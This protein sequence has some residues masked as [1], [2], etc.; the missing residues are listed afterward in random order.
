MEHETHDDSNEREKELAMVKATQ[1][2][3]EEIFD[4]IRSYKE[5]HRPRD[6]LNVLTVGCGGCTS[7]CMAGGQREV[8]ALN[9]ELTEMARGRKVP[10]RFSCTTVERQCNP[11]FL[12]DIEDLVKDCD[13]LLSSAC[14]AGVQH[15]G[16]R[17]PS[18]PVFP[19][20]DTMFLGV[21][22]DTG[23]YEERCRACKKCVLGVTAG[24][25]PLTRCSK[26]VLNGPCGG[27]R[28][29]G[30]CELGTGFRCA[31]NAIYE[32]LKE[33]GRAD[34]L[35][36]IRLPIDWQE[37]G[38]GVLVQKGFEGRYAKAGEKVNRT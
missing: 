19:A 34:D 27:T 20:L 31:W 15:L 23:L 37:R 8:I 33:Q 3:L 9:E 14:G 32:R 28:A 30:N 4:L 10:V 11:Q 29:D 13:C 2:P 6:F 24:I 38:Q 12:E 16:D 36:E 26:G 5:A 22:I 18:K 17:Y 21:D 7:I 1:K 35:L 25:C